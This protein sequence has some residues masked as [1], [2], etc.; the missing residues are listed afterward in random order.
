[1]W[2]L[3]LNDALAR[4]WKE[5]FVAYFKVL[6][7]QLPGGAEE[8]HEYIS[9]PSRLKLNPWPSGNDV[10]T[11]QL[12]HSV[13]KSEQTYKHRIVLFIN[14]IRR[15][16][17]LVVVLEAWTHTC[18]PTR[19]SLTNSPNYSAAANIIKSCFVRHILV[20]ATPISV[21]TGFGRFYWRGITYRCDECNSR[22]DLL[23]YDTALWCTWCHNPEN[24]DLN[25]Q[26]HENLK[27][28]DKCTS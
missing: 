9:R 11:T 4:T 23:R 1:M 22:R 5:A 18:W 19:R 28:R 13:T 6:S 26:S 24:H 10:L 8:N 2:G 7:Q 20:T 21:L 12:R 27:S 17:I 3:S 16:R 25:T 15:T 14:Y